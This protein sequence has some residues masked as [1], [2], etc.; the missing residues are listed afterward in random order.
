MPLS[1]QEQEF[2]AFQPWLQEKF[3]IKTSQSWSQ[4]ILFHA[5]DERDAFERFFSLWEEFS[6]CKRAESPESHSVTV[7]EV[8]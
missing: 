5:V 4:I 2:Q 8:A 6:A 3:G 7:L 1:A